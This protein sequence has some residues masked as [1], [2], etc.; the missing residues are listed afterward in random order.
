MA[1][2]GDLE[3]YAERVQ[4]F[5]DERDWS[6]FHTAKDLAI[7]LAT[8]SAELLELFRF[9][10]DEDARVALEEAGFRQR[11]ADEVG[12]VLFFLVRFCQEF[13]FDLVQAGTDKLAKSEA[14]Y[15]AEEYAGVNRKVFE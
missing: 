4:A 7:G 9:L 15:P 10:S 8:E 1:A 12:D 2:Q 14:K 13:G 11:V 5:T 3:A 6:Q